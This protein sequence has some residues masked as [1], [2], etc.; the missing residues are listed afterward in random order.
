MEWKPNMEINLKWLQ[1]WFLQ[2]SLENNSKNKL[3]YHKKSNPTEIKSKIQRINWWAYNNHLLTL[4]KVYLQII[5]LSKCF[6]LSEMKLKKIE[7]LSK[8][9][10]Q[11]STIR[12][13][14]NYSK[15]RKCWLNPQL[16]RMN[17][18]CYKILWRVTEEQLLLWKKDFQNKLQKMISLQ[19][20]KVKQL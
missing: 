13:W 15:H 3:E 6:M 9:E 8:K 20:T 4:R 10:W 2:V 12:D 19:F 7:I 18:W 17:L 1:C 11:L 5:H 14:K 16:L